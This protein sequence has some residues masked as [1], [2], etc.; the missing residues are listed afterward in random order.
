MDSVF[1]TDYP[2]RDV[3]GFSLKLNAGDKNYGF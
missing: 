1:D 3:A 2:E